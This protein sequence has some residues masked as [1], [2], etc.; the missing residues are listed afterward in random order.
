MYILYLFIFTYGT[1]S[2]WRKEFLKNLMEQVLD[3]C[4]RRHLFFHLDFKVLILLRLKEEKTAGITVRVLVGRLDQAKSSELCSRASHQLVTVC[5]N[6][7]TPELHP[8]N[9]KKRKSRLL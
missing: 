7:E 3:V 5:P 6:I 9:K 4:L 2:G 1:N 8:P